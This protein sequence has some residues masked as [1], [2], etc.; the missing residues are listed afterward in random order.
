MANKTKVLFERRFIFML[1]RSFGAGFARALLNC[2]FAA[3][4]GGREAK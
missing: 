4:K 3:F 1:R 2:Q